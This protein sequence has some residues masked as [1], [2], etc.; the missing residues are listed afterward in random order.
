MWRSFL[1]ISIFSGV[2]LMGSS[3]TLG[4]KAYLSKAGSTATHSKVYHAYWLLGR[5]NKPNCHGR[6]LNFNTS[7]PLWQYWYFIL[8]YE[9]WAPD[10]TPFQS[11]FLNNA[12]QYANKMIPCRITATLGL[13]RP[14]VT[15]KLTKSRYKN[16]NIELRINNSKWPCIFPV[17]TTINYL[18]DGSKHWKE[19]SFFNFRYQKR[20]I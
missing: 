19:N 8:S 1:K 9:W 13:F 3:K 10:V 7:K 16:G 2:F 12:L 20:E 15:N 17:T 14:S 18:T 6:N 11:Y 4:L 5:Q